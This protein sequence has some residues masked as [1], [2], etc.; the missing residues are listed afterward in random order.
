MME[1]Y[2]L[3]PCT[4]WSNAV[5]TK[6]SARHRPEQSPRQFSRVL[7]LRH[8]LTCAR[9][10]RT[11][12]EKEKRADEIT[13]TQPVDRAV[14]TVSVVREPGFLWEGFQPVS[15]RIEYT[16]MCSRGFSRVLPVFDEIE[17]AGRL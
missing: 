14:Q 12:L 11:S 5:S 1:V 7:W 13:L 8:L 17:D 6:S 3:G 10:N 2:N 9:D 4:T 15:N 16:E